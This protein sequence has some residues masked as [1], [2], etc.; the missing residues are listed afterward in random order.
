M[1]RPIAARVCALLAFALALTAACGG[2]DDENA[3]PTTTTTTTT[4]AEAGGPGSST[5]T[6]APASTTTTA[7]GIRTIEVTFAGGQATGGV[8]TESVRLGETVLLRVTSDV[9]EEVH[10]HSYDVV[11]EV[12]AGQTAELRVT[13][14]IPGRFEVEMENRHKQILVLEVR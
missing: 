1:S 10:V 2:D 8:R 9:K 4:T 5:T 12:A 3:S 14:T 6:G 11:A 13:A 7:A